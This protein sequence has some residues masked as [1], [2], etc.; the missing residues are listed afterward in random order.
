MLVLIMM[1]M[2]MIRSQGYRAL[3]YHNNYY[4]SLTIQVNHNYYEQYQCIQ[5]YQLQVNKNEI[6]EKNN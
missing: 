4:H 5:L 2:M 1:M 3:N 6:Y